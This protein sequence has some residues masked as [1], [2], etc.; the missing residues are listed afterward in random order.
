MSSA[1]NTMHD[2]PQHFLDDA[3]HATVPH[4]SLAQDEFLYQGLQ[5]GEVII[6]QMANGTSALGWIPYF[7]RLFLP[8]LPLTL[9]QKG[10]D[11]HKLPVSFIGPAFTP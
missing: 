10:S 4:L 11:Y 3:E 6:A 2:L 9:H 7:A 5:L 1:L 8:C